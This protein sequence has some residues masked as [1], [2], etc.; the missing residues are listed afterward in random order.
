MMITEQSDRQK[1]QIQ[2][3]RGVLKLC[4]APRKT[5]KCGSVSIK[6]FSYLDAE[7]RSSLNVKINRS[8]EITGIALR[9]QR[10]RG[11]QLSRRHDSLFSVV[12]WGTLIPVLPPPTKLS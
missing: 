2:C 5:G 6:S 10:L 3:H 11:L 7:L 12:P 1:T 9:Y 4:S 8:P